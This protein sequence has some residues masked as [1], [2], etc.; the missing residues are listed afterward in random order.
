MLKIIFLSSFLFL[1]FLS[2]QNSVQPFNYEKDTPQWLKE[3]ID[4]MSV[5][6]DYFMSQVYRYEWKDKYVYHIMIPISSCAY[7]ELYE[8]DG[9]KIQFANDAMFSDFLMN[10]KNKVL[11]WERK[12]Y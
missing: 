6:P 4:S 5:N 8:E 9:S 11:V 10:K 12:G 1:A 2:C 7:C 3:K